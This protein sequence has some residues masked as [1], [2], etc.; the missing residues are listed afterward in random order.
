MIRKLLNILY[1]TTPDSYITRDGENIVVLIEGKEKFRMPIHNLEGVVCFNY[2]G[3]TPALMSLCAER[4]V[5][6]SFVSPFGKFLARVTGPFAGNVLLRKRQCIMSENSTIACNVA[7]NCIVAKITNNICVLS[8]GIRDHSKKIECDKIRTALINLK[9][10]IDRLRNCKTLDEV[11]GIEGDSAKIYFSVFDQ[12]I[13]TQKEYFFMQQRTRRPPLDNLNALLSF[14][15]TILAHDVRSALET[16]GLDPFVGFLHCDRPGRPSL[17]LD[18]MEE[19]RPYMVERFVLSLIN[20]KQISEKDF[21]MKE[22][23]GVLIKDDVRKEILRLWQKR[24]QDKIIHP[25]LNEKICVGLLPYAQAMLLA[26]FVRG[27]L[28]GYPPFFWK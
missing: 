21:I 3:V 16:V 19:L 12:L 1:I 10:N 27:D 2:M 7:I 4:G 17:A 26:R 23:G 22:S 5:G 13:V 15:Y 6:L 9:T 20:R 11:R 25:F 8:R 14:F 18:L 28:D 24:K